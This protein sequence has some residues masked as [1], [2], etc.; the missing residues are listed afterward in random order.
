MKPVLPDIRKIAVFRAVQPGAMLCSIPAVRALRNTYPQAHITLV[1]MP[2]AATLL[3][4]F[5]E[6]FDDFIALPGIPM[7]KENFEDFAA[8]MRFENFDLLLQL[9]DNSAIINTLMFQLGARHVAG[10]SH[11]EG[12]VD[13]GMFINYPDHAP[14]ILRQLALVNALGIDTQGSSMEFPVL[15]GDKQEVNRLLLPVYEKSYVVI[16]PSADQWPPAYFGMLADYCIEQGYTLIITGAKDDQPLIREIRKCIH[17][18]VIDLTGQLSTGA[19]GWL[20]RNAFLFITNSTDITQLAAA[21]ATPSLTIS[22]RHDTY[23]WAPLN[24]K[25]HKTIDWNNDT[26]IE[27]V[28]TLAVSL[29][30]QQQSLLRKTG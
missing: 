20:I 19:L 30:Q 25:L 5:P 9:Q 26:H 29:M 7:N 28:F 16:H 3:Q 21:T 24:R 22:L 14:E 18:P 6:Y 1:S 15:P 10:F 23:K 4:R 11:D 27:T 8:H 2:W 12:L 13:S 17:H